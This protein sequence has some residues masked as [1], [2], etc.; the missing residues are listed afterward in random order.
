MSIDLDNVFR[1]KI[2]DLCM[3]ASMGHIQ[4]VPRDPGWPGDH[5]PRLMITHRLLEE[6]SGG[7]QK[8]YHCR[9]VGTDGIFN[10]SLVSF[11]EVELLPYPP[12]KE[13]TTEELVS[14]LKGK[15]KS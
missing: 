5:P 14:R 3:H 12:L 9:V 1:Y 15:T 7:L 11:S 10:T 2:G 8:L 4:S 6:C 13:R